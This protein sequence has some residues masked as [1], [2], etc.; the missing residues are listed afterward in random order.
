MQMN[1]SRQPVNMVHLDT[2]PPHARVVHL[3]ALANKT[4][5]NLIYIY[6]IYQR[7]KICISR[8]FPWEME[9]S[10]TRAGFGDEWEKTHLSCKTM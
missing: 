7:M 6:H 10:P 9:F 2:I 8:G 5:G 4:P 3:I 1:V